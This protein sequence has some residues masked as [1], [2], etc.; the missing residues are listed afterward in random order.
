MLQLTMDVRKKRKVCQ[1][2]GSIENFVAPTHGGSNWAGFPQSLDW[3]Q[4]A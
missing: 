2:L 1:L 3:L 4:L